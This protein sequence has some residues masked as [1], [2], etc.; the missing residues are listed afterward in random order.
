MQLQEN[1]LYLSELATQL[2]ILFS[3][4]FYFCLNGA[5]TNQSTWEQHN[6]KMKAQHKFKLI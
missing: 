5:A 2:F 1:A 6:N 4:V 3:P